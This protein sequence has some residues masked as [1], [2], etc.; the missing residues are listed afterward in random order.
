VVKQ[1]SSGISNSWFWLSRTKQALVQ[2]KEGSQDDIA[3]FMSCYAIVFF[4]VPNRGLNIESLTSMVKGQPNEEL[5]RNLDP[6]SPFLGLLHKMF[7]DCFALDGSQIV[8]F[9]ETKKTPTVEVC[10]PS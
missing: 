1:A 7:Y 2:A 3:V 4:G 8:C 9:Y 10:F 5:L 6:S